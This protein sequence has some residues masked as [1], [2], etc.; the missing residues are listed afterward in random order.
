M[1]D[2]VI[3][4]KNLKDSFNYQN[5]RKQNIKCRSIG[6]GVDNDGMTSVLKILII[7]YNGKNCKN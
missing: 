1:L 5:K 7:S 4:C 3:F 6:Q 2:F